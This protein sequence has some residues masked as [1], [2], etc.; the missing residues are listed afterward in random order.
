M[1]E[2]VS[3]C[4]C[5][6]YIIMP[7]FEHRLAEAVN[8]QNG[9]LIS[10]LLTVDHLHL[11]KHE[12]D[13]EP[14]S[15]AELLNAKQ[16]SGAVTTTT[17]LFK[18]ETEEFVRLEV[19][20]QLRRGNGSNYSQ[21][22]ADVA[23]AVWRRNQHTT[24]TT[25]N[26]SSNS[27]STSKSTSKSAENGVNGNGN[28]DDLFSIYKC[29]NALLVAVNRVAEKYGRWILPVFISTSRDLRRLAVRADASKTST[30][31]SN[32]NHNNHNDHSNIP[33]TRIR[34]TNNA[35]LEEASR[36]IN[37]SFS[38]C[39]NDFDRSSAQSRVWGVYQ[40]MGE[41]FRIY[42]KLRNMALSR[43]VLKVLQQRQKDLPPLDKYPKSH[44][45]TYLYCTGVLL[46]IDEDYT[47]AAAQFIKALSMSPSPSPFDSVSAPSSS[48]PS[49]P[50]PTFQDGYKQRESILTYL[51]PLQIL[52]PTRRTPSPA[53]WAR[54]S[55]LEVLYKPI[56]NALISGDI[57]A[58]D[59]HLLV[60]RRVFLKKHLFLSLSKIRILVYTRL[61]RQVYLAR[62]KVNRIPT[63]L[64]SKALMLALDVDVDV[65]VKRDLESTNVVKSGE[66]VVEGGSI[67]AA[68]VAFL[69][70]SGVVSDFSTD[71]VECY[72]T[73]MIYTGQ[74]KGYI[75]RPH[76]MVV[77]SNKEAF[78]KVH[79]II[80]L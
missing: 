14:E 7:F 76:Q 39:L 51:I 17:T 2:S 33:E 65:P 64:F 54:Y 57:K 19:H 68:P 53:L 67:S 75:S 56:I 13:A 44:V 48:L 27:K 50:P 40:L 23:V 24:T 42:F 28:A 45:I 21:L 34:P 5:I 20:S 32:N 69:S 59:E 38:L 72:L 18:A 36:T 37:K 62:N 78:P 71:Q 43:S 25:T 61:F 15:E 74:M 70:T 49:P 4:L 10:T 1:T 55:R 6:A 29:Q 41:L 77:L 30:T 11:P 3:I 9:S 35:C 31:T 63:P 79:G 22:W 46:V 47:K 66:E 26:S 16:E 60:R 80:A 73:H 52:I 58:F 12:D 8:A